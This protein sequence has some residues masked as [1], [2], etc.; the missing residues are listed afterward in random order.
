[1]STAK[2]LM[3]QSV[4]FGKLPSRGDFVRSAV[5][6]PLI[7][8][9]DEWMS[10]AVELMT[11]DPR[12]KLVYDAALPIHFAILGPG[13]KAGLV[14]HLMASRDTSGRRFPFV[15][16]ASIDLQ[17]PEPFLSYAAHALMPLWHR[18]AD[19]VQ[20]AWRAEEFSETLLS[21]EPV[22]VEVQPSALREEHLGYSGVH[23]LSQLSLWLSPG[24]GTPDAEPV[25]VRQTLL[26]LGMLLQPVRTQGIG[27][28]SKGLLL[29]LPRDAAL[30]AAVMS[31]WTSLIVPFFRST[32]AELAFLL[33]QHAEHPVLLV[34]FHGVSPVTLRSALDREFALAQH[35]QVSEAQWVEEWVNSDYGLRKLSTVLQDDSLSWAAAA[36]VFL[37]VFLGE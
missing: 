36:D 26:A 1:M 29:P 34:G 24:H 5:G 35:L 12:W 21:N 18:Q 28:L 27:G 3:A 31:F 37:E 8:K 4:Y 20:R 32:S 14:G 19:D 9:L 13:H 7:H 16:A 33:S 22:E 11:E 25:S 17:D 30:L 2:A 6:A 15:R 10:Q 23:S